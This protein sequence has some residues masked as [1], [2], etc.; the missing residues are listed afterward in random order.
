LAPFEQATD[1]CQ[2]QNIVTD[3]LIIPCV[4][5]LKAEL[6]EL[7]TNYNSKFVS[8]LKESVYKRLSVYETHEAFQLASIL[9]PRLKMDW[10]TDDE[11]GTLTIL[12]HEKVMALSPSPS[13]TAAPV[14]SPPRKKCKLFRF[15][16]SSTS[17]SAS[18]QPSTP[19]TA[20]QVQTY[21]AQPAIPDDADPLVFWQQQQNVLPQLNT[22]ALRYLSTPASSA[23]VER[24]F[25]IAGKV[26]RPER[27][28][29]SDARFE[30]L[31]FLRCNKHFEL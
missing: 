13:P 25:S 30:E 31:M 9:D 14:Q 6:E 27:C 5:G 2:G 16:S 4:R 15:M 12:L 7:S 10:C 29:I 1:Q 21:L 24:L 11:I 19:A 28:R 8:S 20:A 23:P 3:S 26:F 17:A 22:L 18:P